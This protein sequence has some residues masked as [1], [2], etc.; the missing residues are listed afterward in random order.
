MMEL[1]VPLVYHRTSDQ[2]T[3]NYNRKLRAAMVGPI[4]VFGFVLMATTADELVHLGFP[5][6]SQSWGPQVFG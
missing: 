1:L 2:A 6:L 5:S 4:W 3:L